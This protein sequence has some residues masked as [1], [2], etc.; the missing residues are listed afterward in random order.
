MNKTMLNKK[1]RICAMSD[2]HGQLPNP[3]TIT[4]C[5]AVF[6]CGD[7]VP[8][9]YQR[10]NELSEEWFKTEF[11][12]WVMRIPGKV[13]VIG[14]NHD[15]W[16]FK[17]GKQYIKEK[18]GEWYLDKVVYLEDELIE[19]D[20][21]TIYGCP[22]CTGP[23]NWAFAPGNKY[24]RNPVVVSPYYE[25]ITDCDVL[26]THQPPRV[27]DLGT[28]FYWDKIRRENWGSEELRQCIKEKNITLALCGHIHSGK[29]SRVEYPVR[30]CDTVFYNVSLLNEDHVMTYS[31]L[32]LTLDTEQKTVTEI[33]K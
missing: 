22:W 20:G 8:L 15:F 12:E 1:L 7:I 33:K 14:G 30:G 17:S 11:R 2:L 18:F 19:Y 6:I 16:M 32:Y 13:F 31:P 5:N 9:M 10:Y 25:Q 4:P 27:E 24:S 28:S 26:L 3:N 21:V 23:Q 29:H